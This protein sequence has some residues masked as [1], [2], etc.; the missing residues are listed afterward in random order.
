[1]NA[2]R[3][4]NRFPSS[5]RAI[6]HVLFVVQ[7]AQTEIF[8][9]PFYLPYAQSV[10]QWCI[11]IFRLFRN[12]TLYFWCC[13]FRPRISYRRSQHDQYHT[14]VVRDA[15]QHAAQILVCLAWDSGCF[16]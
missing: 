16:C 10:G 15:E 3:S 2:S 1:M 14:D 12:Q 13:L 4:V 7:I 9:L 11:D 5:L 6:S 8:Q